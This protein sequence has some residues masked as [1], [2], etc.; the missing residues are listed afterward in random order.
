MTGSVIF[1]AA[2]PRAAIW[3]GRSSPL[4]LRHVSCPD[5]GQ[6]RL[7]LRRHP[8]PPAQ[9]DL[10]LEQAPGHHIQ[11][12]GP[13]LVL[14][15]EDPIPPVDGDAVLAGLAGVRDVIEPPENAAQP[16]RLPD[17][18]LPHLLKVD[19]GQVIVPRRG[20][21]LGGGALRRFHFGQQAPLQADDV[22]SVPEVGLFPGQEG[23]L[24][25]LWGEDGQPHRLRVVVDAH[26][27]LV[28]Q[29]AAAVPALAQQVGGGDDA[30]L[31]P[32]ELAVQQRLVAVDV[33]DQ[34]HGGGVDA[35]AVLRTV[36]AVLYGGFQLGQT[37]AVQR[38]GEGV[39]LGQGLVPGQGGQG[40]LAAQRIRHF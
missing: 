38:L 23:L 19:D 8:E 30:G 7:R 9:G 36:H 13:G 33:M 14:I 20:R 15:V 39:L 17:P 1:L 11:V 32:V 3:S 35:D 4:Y 24:P 25:Q 16:D 21:D 29:L 5:G 10:R 28:L 2:S 6:V 40:D 27:E 37:Q 22:L 26:E 12:I 31:S 34:A 18:A